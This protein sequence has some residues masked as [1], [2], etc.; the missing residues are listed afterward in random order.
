MI[1]I[2]RSLDRFDGRAAF[3]KAQVSRARLDGALQRPA[4]NQQKVFDAQMAVGDKDKYPEFAG[5]VIS[6]DTRPMC[7]PLSECPGG[8]DRYKGN[9]Q[10]YLE[11]GNA[12]AEIGQGGVM[13]VGDRA[14]QAHDNLI[15]A[16]TM[17]DLE[18]YPPF[19]GSEFPP[20]RP[21][22][23]LF[24]VLPVPWERLRQLFISICGVSSVSCP[25]RSPPPGVSGEY[26]AVHPIDVARCDD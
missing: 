18:R 20:A 16:N 12:M 5:N 8:R 22:E 23:A 6:I 14:T 21:E 25:N 2:V 1:R 9:A 19:L 7:R 24:H 3:G 10:S 4:P 26:N 11:I 13:M 15:A 17:T